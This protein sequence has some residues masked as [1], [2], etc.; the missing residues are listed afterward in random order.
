MQYDRTELVRPSML[1]MLTFNDLMRGNCALELMAGEFIP[2]MACLFRADIFRATEGF[3]S[4]INCGEDMDLCRH[5]ALCSD[6]VYLPKIV[7]CITLGSA[8]STTDR[9]TG[10]QQMQLARE[11]ILDKTDPYPRLVASARAGRSSHWFGRLVRIYLSSAGWNLR[12]R[13]W[14]T[15]IRRGQRAAHAGLQR[16]GNLVEEDFWLGIRYPYTNGHY[17]RAFLRAGWD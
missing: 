13:R 7:T 1:P 3:Y 11:R 10:V 8:G 9:R 12:R 4:M 16:F 2:L 6:L 15:A 5:A 14:G 17:L